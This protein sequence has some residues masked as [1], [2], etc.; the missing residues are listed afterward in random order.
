MSLLHLKMESAPLQF[1]NHVIYLTELI[2]HYPKSL[3][4][5]G[6]ERAAARG[7]PSAERS[8]NACTSKTQAI[9]SVV[10]DS[11]GVLAV[12]ESEVMASSRQKHLLSRPKASTGRH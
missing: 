4:D 7:A 11:A 1:L 9:S 5:T 2:Q 10:S 12:T 6:I 3:N 8:I